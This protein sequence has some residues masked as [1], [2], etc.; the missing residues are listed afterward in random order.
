MLLAPVLA[1]LIALLTAA[2]SPAFAGNY[3]TL[4]ADVSVSA[5]VDATPEQVFS[6]LL[7]LHHLEAMIPCIGKW[8]M[9][10]RTFGEGASAMV[11][12]DIAALHRKLPVSLSRADAPY[13]IDLEH[14][15]D[16]GFTTVISL[17]EVPFTPEGETPKTNVTL[18]TPLNPPPWPFRKYYYDAVQTEWKKCY[19]TTLENLARAVGG[20]PSP[21]PAPGGETDAG[22]VA[23]EA[24]TR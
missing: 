3:D 8:E 5:P 7:D 1:P 18:L 13:R 24:G 10:Q 12:Y 15:G 11:R 23:D 21:I 22:G 20:R 16:L 19:A 14:L 6:Y 17:R 9:S 4:T 2:V